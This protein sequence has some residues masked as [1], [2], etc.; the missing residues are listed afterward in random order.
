MT[1]SG[2]S[3]FSLPIFQKMGGVLDFA[4]K[5]AYHIS[6]VALAAILCLIINEVMRRYFFNSPTTWAGDANQWLFAVATL[7]ALPEITR[8]NGNVAI[9]ILLERMPQ[10]RRDF[11][12]RVL[13]LISGVACLL[14]L[15]ISGVESLRQI[16]M[17]ITTNWIYPVPKWWVSIAIPIGFCLS[18]LQ[19]FRLM[20]K[21]QT[22]SPIEE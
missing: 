5:I 14:A 4:T 10:G 22:N 13:F 11:F 8:V 12:A 2:N 9:T 16:D 6:G 21:P 18:S 15:Y 1:N 7:M 3:V 17:G 20:F 19:F